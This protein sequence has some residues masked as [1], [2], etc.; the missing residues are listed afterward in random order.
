MTATS[1]PT[2]TTGDNRPLLWIVLGVVAA[3][4]VIFVGNYHVPAGENGGTEE[5]VSTAVIC[6]V[7]AVVLFVAVLPRVQAN[8]RAAIVLGVLAILSLVVFWSGVTPILAAAAWVAADREVQPSR[9]VTVVRWLA[10]AAAV[11]TVVVTLAEN[12]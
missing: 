4:V 12:L 8:G 10:L 11:L 5:G 7:L 9:G 6:A 3:A 2:A 1:E